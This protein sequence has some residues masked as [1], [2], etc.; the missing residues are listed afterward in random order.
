MLA[1]ISALTPMELM[2][3]CHKK[4][5]DCNGMYKIPVK[6]L[7]KIVKGKEIKVKAAKLAKKLIAKNEKLKCK[8]A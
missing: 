4:P 3:R 7:A 5:T 8:K 6:D 2:Q 1:D